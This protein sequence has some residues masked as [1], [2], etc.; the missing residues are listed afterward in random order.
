MVMTSCARRVPEPAG[1]PPGVPHIS[2]TIMHGDRDNPDAQFACQSTGPQQCVVPASRPESRTF[3]DVHL[4]LH[5]AG[6]ETT[7]VG[8]Y[9]IE[10][11]DDG[12]RV[13]QDSPIRTTV[14]GEEEIANHSI[15]GIVTTKPGTYTLRLALN[16]TTGA[17][18]TPIREEIHVLVQ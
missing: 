18:S 15:T 2:W 3:S 5:G 10:F 13:V 12:D 1:L 11:F 9:R 6:R 7:Y 17:G 8:N 14:H 16:A 4:Y